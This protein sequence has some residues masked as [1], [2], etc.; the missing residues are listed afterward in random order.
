M[1]ARNY[2]NEKFGNLT[3]IRKT[4]NIGRDNRKLWLFRCDCGNEVERPPGN[5]VSGWTKSCGCLAKIHQQTTLKRYTEART[6]PNQMGAKNKLYGRYKNQA[7]ARGILF[8]LPKE[9]FLNLIE[10]QC[11]YCN[12][13]PSS[14]IYPKYQNKSLFAV[15][16]GIDRRDNRK[17]Y[18][19]E[20]CLT[21][22]GI[23]NKMKMAMGYEEFLQ[24][25][26]KIIHNMG[27]II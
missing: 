6:Q 16:N 4:E 7:K 17:G 21:C 24:H 15:Y 18:S 1:K 27:V 11:H 5:I 9:L 22:C 23:C 12:S 2:T 20:N 19:E 14:V 25:I 3:A 26:S 13:S 10:Q 8:E